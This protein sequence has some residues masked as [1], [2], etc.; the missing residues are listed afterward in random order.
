MLPG[1]DGD[2]LAEDHAVVEDAA[3]LL[4]VE[5]CVAA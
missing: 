5:E 1:I 4:P 3:N 2:A